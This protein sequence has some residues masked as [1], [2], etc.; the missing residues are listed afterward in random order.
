[1]KVVFLLAIIV[2]LFATNFALP[3]DTNLARSRRRRFRG[4]PCGFRNSWTVYPPCRRR[5]GDGRTQ[6]WYDSRDP[7][8]KY[9]KY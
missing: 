2:A 9:E 8:W 1:M 7:Y 5:P 3:Y 6:E 4:H